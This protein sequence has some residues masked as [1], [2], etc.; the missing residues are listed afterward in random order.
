MIGIITLVPNVILIFV[1]SFLLAVE[2]QHII[3]DRRWGL[4]LLL[5]VILTLVLIKIVWLFYRAQ[6]NSWSLPYRERRKA[7]ERERMDDLKRSAED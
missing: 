7:E 4:W 5:A 6:N 3:L 2:R 1:V